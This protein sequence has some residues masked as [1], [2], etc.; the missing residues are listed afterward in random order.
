MVGGFT[1]VDGLAG[2]PDPV[3]AYPN[4]SPYGRVAL[5]LHCWCPRV[6][7]LFW[8]CTQVPLC[9]P[10][11][12]FPEDCFCQQD[13]P[14]PFAPY[15]GTSFCGSDFWKKESEIHLPLYSSLEEIKAEPGICL[16]W[17]QKKGDSTRGEQLI[18]WELSNPTCFQKE[19][20]FLCQQS[21][22]VYL[23]ILT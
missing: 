20:Q 16:M 19:L 4:P 23:L 5:G 3:P 12:T 7:F 13:V 11:E 14:S 8:G 9:S 2:I 10:K 1:S 6:F 17:D 21:W 22:S 15:Q 18:L